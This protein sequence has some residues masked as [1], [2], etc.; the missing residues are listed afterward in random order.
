MRALK[1]FNGRAQGNKRGTVALAAYSKK[2]AKELLE[3][4]FNTFGISQNEIRDYFSECWGTDAASI[5]EPT[6]PCL[7]YQ[8]HYGQPYV[9]LV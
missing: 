8:E 6:E 2:Q 9:R 1:K 7:Y 3:K 5:P 4:A